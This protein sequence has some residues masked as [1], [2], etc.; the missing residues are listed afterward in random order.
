[1]DS[2]GNVLGQHKGIIYYTIGQRRGLGLSLKQ[3]GYVI[4]VRKD[5]NEVVVG[6]KDLLFSKGLY[7][8]QVNWMSIPPFDGERRVMAKI[9]YNSKEVPCRVEMTEDQLV[10]VTFEE[11]QRAVT[12]GQAVVFYEG[13]IVVGGAT[14]CSRF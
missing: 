7:G 10:K 14:I 11:P 4:D 8:E 12:P 1:M 5:T 9:R 2:E 3:P 13:D 6:T